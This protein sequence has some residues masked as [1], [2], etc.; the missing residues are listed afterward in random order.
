MAC[1]LLHA[2]LKICPLASMRALACMLLYSHALLI[3]GH[4]LY[5][6]FILTIS[7]ALAVICYRKHLL[8]CV[9][10]SPLITYNR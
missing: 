3:F 7:C 2:L 6:S 4:R 8:L 1:Q 5:A 10:S 9:C